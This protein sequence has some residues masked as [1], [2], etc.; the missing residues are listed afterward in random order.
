MPKG[1]FT[2]GEFAQLHKVNK[3]TLHYYDEI[4][5]FKPKVKGDNGYR[6]YTY[7]QS[8]E[9]E[10]I[11][12]FRELGM[13]IEEITAYFNSPNAG[14]FQKII[15]A[16]KQEIKSQ[17]QNLKALD[18]L[19]QFKEN[20]LILSQTAD[21]D[22]IEIVPCEGEYLLLSD[23]ITGELD[24]EDFKK[25]FEHTKDYTTRLFNQSYGS[26]IS[27]AN[28]LN[29]NYTDYTCFFTQVS[30]EQRRKGLFQKPKGNYLRAFCKGNWNLLPAC[31]E[32]II[33][34]AN[35]QGLTLTGYAY[36]V[37]INE[38]AITSID[39]YITQITIKCD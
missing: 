23:D 14:A 32:K 20:Q 1:L 5:L 6:Y 19:L 33:N 18:K 4:G 38:M 29:G 11:L 27:A 2:T 8:S 21:F 16:K 22:K 26:M 39:E 35:K 28:L 13:S 24:E 34:Y 7:L 31:Y 10:M 36:E 9:F 3:R 17:I 30:K 37:G 25:L 15:E 12:A